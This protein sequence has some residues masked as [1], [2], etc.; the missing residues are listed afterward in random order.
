MCAYALHVRICEP[1]GDGISSLENLLDSTV[2]RFTVWI[3]AVVA[4]VGNAFV[5]ISR[6][7]IKES[8]IV[9]SFYIK[10][11]SL[12][13]LLMGIY[14]FIIAAYD[15]HFRGDYIRQDNIWRHSWQCNFCGFLR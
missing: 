14:L 12:A 6:L 1:K 7:L 5:L 4:C 2:L 8:N 13:D 9:H 15:V 11:L 10:N 3:V